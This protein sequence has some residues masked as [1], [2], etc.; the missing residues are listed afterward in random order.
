[1]AKKLLITGELLALGW[2]TVTEDIRLV[3]LAILT[4]LGGVSLISLT[5]IRW[6]LAALLTLVATSAVPRADWSIAGLRLHPEHV[7]IGVLGLVV[8]L[9][10]GRGI[11]RLLDLRTFDYFLLAYVALN[12]FSSTFASPEPNRTLRWAV[13]Q[14]L[15]MA[16]YFLIRVIA[17]EKQTLWKVWRFL[18]LVGSLESLYGCIS[19][20]SN[21]AFGTRFGVEV[22]QYGTIPGTYGTQ[23]E[24]NLFGS[25]TACTALMCL[26]AFLISRDADRRWYLYGFIISTVAMSISLSRAVFLSFFLGIFVVLWITARVQQLEIRRVVRLT[27]FGTLVMLAVS[28]VI[29]PMLR[30]RFENVDI[31]DV[32]SDATLVERLIQTKVAMDNIAAHPVFGSG[33]ASFQL[34]FNWQEYLPEM[35]DIAGWLGNTPLRILHDTGIVGLSA[36]VAFIASLAY[37]GR[38]M[39]QCTEPQTR[40]ILLT[41]TSG[42]ILYG[43][44]F[45]STEATTLAFTWVHLGLFANAV[46]LMRIEQSSKANPVAEMRQL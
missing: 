35:G 34:F 14:A 31:T 36:F 3:A 46:I 27:A 45:Q 15:V 11:Y 37:A 6:P 42:A 4:V 7:V 22:E 10:N 2:L 39:R 5:L 21:R 16:P 9:R 44:T 38:S 33:T 1:V 20:L 29:I 25:Y 13:L 32:T 26:A 12:F 19:L 17:K 24:A 40:I 43:M 8:L 41:L 30:E 18:L 23:Y 28:P